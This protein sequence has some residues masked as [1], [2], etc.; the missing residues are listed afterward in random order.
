M[1]IEI[2]ISDDLLVTYLRGAN[3]RYWG[4]RFDWDG[5]FTAGVH[6]R[7][8]DVV[9]QLTRKNVCAGL[10]VLATKYPH[11]FAALVADKGDGYTG[12]ALVQCAL[13]GEL[14]YG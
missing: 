4:V 10:V 8:G 1:K 14:K 12:D 9:H 3:V 6:E 11:H 5:G 7:D 13:F 2:E